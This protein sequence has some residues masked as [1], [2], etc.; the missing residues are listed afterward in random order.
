MRETKR[1]K[2]MK[3]EAKCQR[4]RERK[5][6]CKEAVRLQKRIMCWCETGNLH[7]QGFD[8]KI[9]EKCRSWQQ[10]VA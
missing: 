8:V 2:E 10:K 1:N 3:G 6:K 5:K 4:E 9:E 7:V